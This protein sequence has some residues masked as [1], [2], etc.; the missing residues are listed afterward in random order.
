MRE[1]DRLK[2]ELAEAVKNSEEYENYLK[3]KGLLAGKPDIERTVDEMRRQNF[4]FQNSEGFDNSSEAIDEICHR[5]ESV[6]AQ[7]VAN[8]FLNAETCLC[9]MIQ[10]ICKTIIEDIDFNLDFLK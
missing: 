4:E 3:C 6:S 10:D 8:E 9:R 1:I 2:C 7:D 5:Y